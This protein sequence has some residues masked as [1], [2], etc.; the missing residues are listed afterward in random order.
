MTDMSPIWHAVAQ[1]ATRVRRERL[2]VLLDFLRQSENAHARALM[3]IPWPEL[4]STISARE[5]EMQ[6]VSWYAQGHLAYA[7]AA[8]WLGLVYAATKEMGRRGTT[9]E[10]TR[11][12]DYQPPEESPFA[13]ERLRLILLFA[14]WRK[15]FHLW[16]RKSLKQAD[17]PA[18]QA[19]V[20]LSA[21]IHGALL[22]RMKIDQL[23][24][25]MHA[26]VPLDFRLGLPTI[27][28]RLP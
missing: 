28:F 20:V 25:E 27:P 21:I 15:S 4:P 13:P 7:A 26:E 12:S 2:P 8:D 17:R 10:P 3:E 11:L 19:A 18:H 24:S 6:I 1:R 14:S 9:L 22:D 23:V 16:L 5:L